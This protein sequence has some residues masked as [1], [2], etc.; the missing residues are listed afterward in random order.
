[1]KPVAIFRHFPA[2]GPGFLAD[3]L[4]EQSIPWRLVRV[5]AGDSVPDEACDYSG[6]VFMGGPMSVNDDLSWPGRRFSGSSCS[7][8]G[9]KSMP[10]AKTASFISH[11]CSRKE[12]L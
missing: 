7:S 11:L 4:D 3:F 1:M 12:R 9:W 5:D 8:P 10:G 2:E 6:L